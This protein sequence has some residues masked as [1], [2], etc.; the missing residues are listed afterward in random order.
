M[1]WLLCGVLVAGAV[2]AADAVAAEPPVQYAANPFVIALDVSPPEDSAGGMVVADADGD[3][4]MDFLVTVP[5]H[6]ACYG[7]D[8]TKLWLRE[9]AVQVGGSSER[10]GLPGHHG[11]GV[12]AGDVDGDGTTEVLFLARDGVLHVAASATGEDEWTAAPPAPAGSERWEHLVIV[13]LRGE[14]DCDLL[15]QATNAEGYRVGRYLAAY[16]LERLR[17]GDT[18]PLWRRDDFLACAHNG[19][20]AADLDGDGRDEILGG[21]I[22]GSGG[23]VLYTI[24]LKGHIDSIF[25]ADV[26]PDVAGLEVVA[27]EEGGGNRVFLYNGKGL[28]WETHYQ[29]WEPQNAAVGDFDVARPGLEIW[30]R[31]RFNEHQKPFLFDA[32]GALVLA[33]E[34]GDVAPDTWTD[35]G[36]EVIHTIDW[37]GE[38]KQLAA[39]K[40]RHT[41]G[42]VCVFDPLGGRFVVDL[43]DEADRV[44]VADVSGDWREEIVVLSGNTLR[45]YHNAAPNPGPGRPRLWSQPHY[46]RSKLSH[47]Y[48]SP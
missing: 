41:S 20:R 28:L 3:G 22:V 43:V 16:A 38:G 9:C 1:P 8:G 40:E 31:S 27:L 12:T 21:T 23:D 29:H 24:P 45:V 14:G 10:Y 5:G 36:V 15:L 25:V 11:P 7:H 48:Y 33:Y 47:N 42:H 32:Q 2:F 34:M 4:R 17:A 13:D 26:R 19:A 44:Y 46:R 6:V 39:A 18:E 37:S 30:C 35:S